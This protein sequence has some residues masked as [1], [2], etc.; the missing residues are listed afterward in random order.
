MGS[1]TPHT[2]EDVRQMLDAIGIGKIEDLFA[3]IPPQLR[4]QRPLNLP[5]GLSEAETV[6]KLKDLAEQNIATD[7]LACFIGAGIYDHRV[8][9]VINHL[10][11]RGDFFTAYTPYQA[12]IAQG[13]LQVIYEYQSLMCELTGMDLANASMYEGATALGEAAHMSIHHTGRRKL[14]ILDSVH[15]EY[16]HVTAG[17]MKNLGTEIVIVPTE[18]GLVDMNRLAEII[19]DKTASVLIQYPNFFG[20]IDDIEAIS[21]LAKKVGALT[22]VSAYPIALGMLRPPGEM[23]ADIVTGEG[24]SLGIGMS[25]GGPSL[26]FMAVKEPLMRKIPGRISGCTNDNRGQRGF[27]LTLQARE[28]HIRREKATS[29]ICSNQALMA[30]NATIYLALLGRDGLREVASHSLQKAH[31]F[32]KELGKAGSVEMPF[33]APFFNE[34]V[35][36]VPNSKKILKKLENEGILGGFPLETFYP[37]LKDHVL[38]AVTEKRSVL[39]MDMYKQL[40]GGTNA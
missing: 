36:K 12:E 17:M 26:G 33:S 21:G 6:Q 23:G 3:E 9:C 18:D 35:I 28:Q 27:V 19:D 22:V 39:E 38:V 8:P 32:K 37:R 11:L 13:T 1:Y 40:L 34:F 16:R 2:P 10:L 24:Q 29:N 20:G 30:L 5:H 31:Y 14:V 4:L 25:F 7:E 15:P